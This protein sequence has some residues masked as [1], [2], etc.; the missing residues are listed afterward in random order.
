MYIKYVDG[1]F[2]ERRA[3]EEQSDDRVGLPG[4]EVFGVTEE[5]SDEMDRPSKHYE[6]CHS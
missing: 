4:S 5:Q 3:R 2:T 6:G 1:M